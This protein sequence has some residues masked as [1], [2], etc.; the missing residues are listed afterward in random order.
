MLKVVSPRDEATDK[1]LRAGVGPLWQKIAVWRPAAIVF[2]Y[3]RGAN[4]AA[5][6]DLPEPWGHLQDVALAGRPC[7]L[8]PGPVRH[9]RTGGR[10]RELPAE[11]GVGPAGRPSL[12]GASSDLVRVGASGRP[13]LSVVVL[14]VEVRV[15]LGPLD[16]LQ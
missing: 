8:M 1:E 11:P 6:R 15:V 3:K 16:R 2:I 5:G 14:V 10:G 7:V 9:D 12:G 4:A 13:R